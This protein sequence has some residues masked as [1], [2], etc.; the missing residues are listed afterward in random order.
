MPING[1]PKKK[2]FIDMREFLRAAAAWANENMTEWPWGG[3]K[4]E[5]D[6]YYFV[7]VNNP[8]ADT[9]RLLPHD[10]AG[11]AAEVAKF[12]TTQV[13]PASRSIPPT[14]TGSVT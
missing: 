10:C 5:D 6:K 14:D 8:T 13:V 2:D 3:P 11:S 4:D 1:K 7:V 9:K 12:G